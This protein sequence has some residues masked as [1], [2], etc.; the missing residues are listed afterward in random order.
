[1][2]LVPTRAEMKDMLGGCLGQYTFESELKLGDYMSCI[3]DH[4]KHICSFEHGMCM[5]H[6]K[7]FTCV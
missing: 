3:G 6:A 7:P 5:A 1:M 2:V 4:Y